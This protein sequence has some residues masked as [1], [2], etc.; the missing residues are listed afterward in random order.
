MTERLDYFSATLT[1]SFSML[2]TL[3]RVFNLI[4]PSGATKLAVPTVIVVALI[5]LSHYTYLL[6]FP[7][8]YGSFP[9]GYHTAFNVI[10][11]LVHSFSWIGWTSSFY[12][13]AISEI[14]WPRPYPPQDPLKY[15]S[16]NASTPALLV[17]LTTVAMSFELLDF[18]P[19]FRLLD[20]HAMWH[21]S[22]IP[23][24]MAWWHFLASDAIELE[25]A[26]IQGKS[27][28]GSTLSGG[29]SEKM[30]LTGGSTLSA[31]G[32]GAEGQKKEG[33]VELG[34]GQ[35]QGGV[36]STDRPSTPFT[37]N[38][39]AFAKMAAGLGLP[40]RSTPGKTPGGAKER[41]D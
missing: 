38:V 3:L 36:E 19:I 37:P 34:D 33:V 30:P 22:T 20:A 15:K 31:S 8:A 10:L 39:P 29:V 1:I 40:S 17:G 26:Q 21:L 9:Y 32:T 11:A 4:T 25:G 12:I 5:V 2:Y 41:E 18:A 24:G 35:G 16:P 6:S 28:G 27:N 13:P 14:G 7:V 23:L